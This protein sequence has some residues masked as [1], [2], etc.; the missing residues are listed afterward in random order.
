MKEEEE[1]LNQLSEP[2]T[3][4]EDNP[5]EDMLQNEQFMRMVDILFIRGIEN[6]QE[7]GE[8]QQQQQQ[9]QEQVQQEQVQ[10]EQVQQDQ[11]ELEEDELPQQMPTPPEQPDEPEIPQ[12]PEILD[13]TFFNS[14]VDNN[15]STFN[16]IF[17]FDTE[18]FRL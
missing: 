1:N 16:N 13:P 6:D 8:E 11:M 2:Q 15:G 18:G 10:Q 7:E 3:N 9:Q 12:L 14:I 4:E 17:S 5:A